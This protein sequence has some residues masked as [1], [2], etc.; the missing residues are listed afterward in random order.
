MDPPSCGE[1]V[2]AAVDELNNTGVVHAVTWESLR[3]PGRPLIDKVL[4]EID[5]SDVCAFDVTG[6]NPNVMFE[7]GYAIGAG[8]RVLASS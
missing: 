6:L 2:K 4:G 7:L 5:R 8:K 3:A 1:T